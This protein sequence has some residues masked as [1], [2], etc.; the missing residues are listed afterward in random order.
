PSGVVKVLLDHLTSDRVEVDMIELSGPAFADVDNR[1]MSLELV[2]GG[3][4][5]AAMFSAD[6]QVVQP[7]DALHKKCLLIERGSFRPVTKVSVDMLKCAQAQFIQEPGV[8]GEDVVVLLEM[9]LKN[10]GDGV[11]GID[12]RD[13]LD[14]ADILATMGRTVLISNYGEYHRL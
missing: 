2:Q 10:L 1:L 6:G 5:H 14:R 9:T 12:A 4:T 13:F 11:E 8:Q 7:S 3:L